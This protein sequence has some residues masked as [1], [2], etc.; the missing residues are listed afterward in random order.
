[1]HIFYWSAVK[2]IN[3]TWFATF[4][5]AVIGLGGGALCILQFSDY[6]WSLFLGLP[7]LVSFLS[8]FC[9]S[10]RRP[11]SFA[12][13]YGLSAVSLLILGGVIL[14]FAL[15]GLICLLMALPLTLVLALIG[16]ALGRAV[17]SSCGRDIRSVTPF[18][19]LLLFPC[20]VAFDSQTKPEPIVRSV[21]TSVVV[22]APIGR[23][24]DVVVAF[25]RIA[26]PPEGIFR[27]G[28][29]YP[30]EAHIEGSGV[31]AIRYC[32]FSTGSF[33]EPITIWKRPELLAFNVISNPPPMREI[34][35][36][37]NL[38]ARHLQGYMVSKH[39]QFHL[40]Q[41]DGKVMLE[42]TTWYTHSL[43][44]Q[45]YWGPISDQIIHRIHLRVLDHIREIAES[46]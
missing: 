30:M 27:L 43:A 22:S 41:R 7:I 2:L 18:L 34:S 31:G 21:T 44:P 46:N 36:Y 5:P 45:W 8:A 37:A 14:T 16:A 17:G 32:T 11:V 6:G 26:K 38:E 19:L 15:D 4:I 24:W 28:I 25:P 13:A 1:M 20:L 39:G 40:I 33:V 10:F 23:V 3:K 35:L 42:G 29:A 9:T 12:K